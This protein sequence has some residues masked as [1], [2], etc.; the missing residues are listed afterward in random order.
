M[1]ALGAGLRTVAANARLLW[2]LLCANLIV[3]AL[4]VLPLLTP[5]EA[6]LSHHEAAREMTH[7]LDMPWWVDV[8]TAH[9]ESFSRTLDLVSVSAFLS[10]LLSCFFAGGLLQAYE[11]TLERRAMD[12]FMVACRRWF[13]RFVW[14][15]ALSLPLYW[16]VHRMINTHLALFVDDAMESVRDERVGVLITWARAAL[17]LVLFDLVTLFGDYARVHAVVSAQRSMLASLSAGMRFVLRHPLRV[18]SLEVGTIVLQA[19]AL[20]LYLPVDRLLGRESAAG[21]AAA[22]VASEAFVLLRLYLRESSRAGQMSVYR[23]ARVT[24]AEAGAGTVS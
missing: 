19:G 21:L 3:A 18:G 24:G 20:A 15:F 13:V 9:A 4:A 6:T 10:A 5:I 16:L 1:T 2:W 14:L 11:D 17:F 22:F 8:T 12:R 23:A 7:R